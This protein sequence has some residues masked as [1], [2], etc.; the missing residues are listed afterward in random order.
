MLENHRSK[1]QRTICENIWRIIKH[2]GGQAK[3][4]LIISGVFFPVSS[5]G[6][7]MKILLWKALSAGFTKWKPPKSSRKRIRMKRWSWCVTTVQQY[8]IWRLLICWQ[9]LECVSGNWWHLI[10][11]ISISTRANVLYL[12]RATRNDWYTLTHGRRS[13]FKTILRADRMKTRLCL[14][15]WKLPLTDWWLAEWRH[16]FGSWESVWISRRFT[17]TSSGVHWLQLP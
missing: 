3:L 13:T 9:L 16:A 4:R 14:F 7:K 5:R 17:L 12:V 1:L 2:S 10:G 15:P 8:E 11:R 6:W